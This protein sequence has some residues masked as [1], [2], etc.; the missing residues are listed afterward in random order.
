MRRVLLL[1]PAIGLH[2]LLPSPGAAT[3]DDPSPC[4]SEL[5]VAP[6]GSRIA[7]ISDV[8]GG[9]RNLAL[10]SRDGLDYRVLLP[11]NGR[12]ESAPD[13]SP[14]G[15]KILFVSSDPAL[16]AGATSGMKQLWTVQSNG[17]SPT[18]LW[19]S[20]LQ[21]LETPRWSPDG[22]RIAFISDGSLWMLNAN[23][24][25][26]RQLTARGWT[27]ANPVWSPD[28]TQLAVNLSTRGLPW[29][30][31]VFDVARLTAP[32][33]PP[34]IFSVGRR[35]MNLEATDWLA[36]WS[37]REGILLDSMIPSA[38][39]LADSYDAR[40]SPNARQSIGTWSPRTRRFKAFG[41]GGTHYMRDMRW[42]PQGPGLFA[43][44]CGGEILQALPTGIVNVI[45][46]VRRF[47]PG[48]ADDPDL[49]GISSAQDNCPSI[50]NRDQIDRARPNGSTP[51]GIG[52]ACQSIDGVARTS[53][54]QPP[55]PLTLPG[56]GLLPS[57]QS[58]TPGQAVASCDG[59]FRLVHQTDGNVVLYDIV[60]GFR[61]IFNTGTFDKATSLLIMQTDGNLVLYSPSF[62]PLYNTGTFGNPGARL[63][64][65]DDGNLVIYSPSNVPLFATYTFVR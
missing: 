45:L 22:Q 9:D 36:D 50:Y 58:L 47:E 32:S 4:F 38:T 29:S 41:P 64:V 31:F 17:S 39:P 51:D 13:W 5:D 57:G 63:A 15:T 49:D 7:F 8:V 25:S 16:R 48:P 20:Q 12:I 37:A 27:L 55:P 46:G 18:L 59:R 3:P 62:E 43:S 10:V 23:G 26:P 40:R 65:Q 21:S 44:V 33:T 42:D 2:L 35:L 60:H 11:W 34:D 61:P 56:C 54:V 52:D 24:T 19:D 14:D 1:I 28:G 30:I 53:F 6:D